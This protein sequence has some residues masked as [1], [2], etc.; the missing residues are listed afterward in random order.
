MYIQNGVLGMQFIM[1]S[2]VV[3]QRNTTVS[4]ILSLIVTPKNEAQTK[5]TR[6]RQNKMY[7]TLSVTFTNAHIV[8]HIH[9]HSHCQSHSPTL[10]LSLALT[11]T[12][13]HQ[14]SHFY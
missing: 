14:H 4:S 11:S 6:K 1:D 13:T 3:A 10:T 2:F 7:P 12:H 8:S 5:K 9:Q